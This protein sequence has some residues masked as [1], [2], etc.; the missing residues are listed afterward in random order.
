M[1]FKVLPKHLFNNDHSTTQ[2]DP[3]ILTKTTNSGTITAG[4][5]TDYFLIT[6][7]STKLIDSFHNILSRKYTVRDL[8]PPSNYL[9]CTITKTFTSP[10]HISQPALIKNSLA[11]GVLT[12]SNSKPLPLPTKMT[13]SRIKKPTL[14]YKHNKELYQT[15]IGDIRYLA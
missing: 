2:S 4:I 1:Y 15:I 10:I 11:K 3:F 9:G 6:V 5:T 8:V 12:H 14:L 13:T 7:P